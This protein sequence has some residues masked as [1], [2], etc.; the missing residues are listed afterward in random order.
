MKASVSSPLVTSVKLMYV[1]CPIVLVALIVSIFERTAGIARD[2]LILIFVLGLVSTVG[3]RFALLWILWKSGGVGFAGGAVFEVH[4]LMAIATGILGSLIFQ[5]PWNTLPLIIAM[6]G[7]WVLVG[8]LRIYWLLRN[9]K[10]V[11]Q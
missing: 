5:R 1:A 9:K 7:L 4:S 2:V 6:Y 3:F 8:R 11:I 10:R